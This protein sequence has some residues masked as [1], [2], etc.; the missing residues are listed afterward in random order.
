MSRRVVVTGMGAITPIGLG[1]EEFWAGVRAGKTGFGEI[2]ACVISV[3]IYPGATA[4]TVIFRLA[5]SFATD[6]VSPITPAFDNAGITKDNL[7]I[8]MTDQDFDAVIETNLKG[9]FNTMKHMYRPFLKQKAGRIINLS[10]VTGI[11]GNAGQAN[12]AASN[13]Y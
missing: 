6:F 7:M 3:S 1:V 10:S 9:T 4:L 12:Y 5:S 2:M 11:L 8:R 13:A